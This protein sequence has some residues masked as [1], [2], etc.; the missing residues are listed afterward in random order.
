MVYPKE[1][2]VTRQRAWPLVKRAFPE[3]TGRKFIVEFR[4]RIQFHDTNWS[5]G[6]RNEYKFVRIDGAVGELVIGAPWANPEEGRIYFMT[7]GV[8]VIAHRY[9]CGH[10]MGITI[11]AHP[12]HL[13][14]WL[15]EAK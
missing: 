8:I 9:F 10:D 11:Y 7:M 1:L 13:P 4:D 2:K 6:T 3:Y 14:K 12:S 15:P 5:G